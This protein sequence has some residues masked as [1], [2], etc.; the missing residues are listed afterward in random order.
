MIYDPIWYVKK[1][2]INWSLR[3]PNVI[4]SKWPKSECLKVSVC[5]KCQISLTGSHMKGSV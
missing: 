2:L 5:S 3:V 1:V 4:L